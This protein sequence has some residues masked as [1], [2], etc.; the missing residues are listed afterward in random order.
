[1]KSGSGLADAFGSDPWRD[2][3]LL[4]FKLSVPLHSWPFCL[5]F[6]AAEI[7]MRRFLTLPLIGCAGDPGCCVME[8]SGEGV[9]E[10]S[11]GLY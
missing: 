10:E 1:M 9:L 2:F 5:G 4:T 11:A 3:N 6:I 7:I 8:G